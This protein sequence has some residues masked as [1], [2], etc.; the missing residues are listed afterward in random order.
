M[1]EEKYEQNSSSRERFLLLWT[2]KNPI[3]SPWTWEDTNQVYHHCL[4]GSKST[5]DHQPT[6]ISERNQQLAVIDEEV[7]KEFGIDTAMFL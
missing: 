2:I 7:L 1:K 4:R 6:K 5:G 3:G